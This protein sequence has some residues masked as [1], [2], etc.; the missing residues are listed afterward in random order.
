MRKIFARLGLRDD[1]DIYG[2][3]AIGYPE[4][5]PA[6]AAP[7]KEGRVILIAQANFK[8]TDKGADTYHG[9]EERLG[10]RL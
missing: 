6:K 9:S 10:Q 2:S 5:L 3:V 1:E 4:L 8:L 7:R